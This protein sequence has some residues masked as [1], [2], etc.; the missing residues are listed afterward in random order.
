MVFISL[1]VMEVKMSITTLRTCVF[2][3]LLHLHQR[4][5]NLFFLMAILG[6][7]T[8]LSGRVLSS[9]WPT[10]L[11]IFPSHHIFCS[12][13][14]HPCFPLAEALLATMVK[15]ILAVGTKEVLLLFFWSITRLALAGHC[16][17][18]PAGWR[19]RWGEGE[20]GTTKE[21]IWWS[22]RLG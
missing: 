20:G 16:S 21:L 15:K 6:F 19:E 7:P 2:L 8:F 17:D 3:S 11:I 10:V 9:I 18:H 14:S 13:P 1:T 22:W 5:V 12:S 4:R